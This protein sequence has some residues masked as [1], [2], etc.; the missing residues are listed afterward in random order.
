[1]SSLLERRRFR[2]PPPGHDAG[3][4]HRIWRNLAVAAVFAVF[5]LAIGAFALFESIPL[6]T[7]DTF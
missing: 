5:G 3:Q 1:M 4:P 6:V 2:Q 7:I